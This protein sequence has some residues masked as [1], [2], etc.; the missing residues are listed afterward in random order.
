M[1]HNWVPRYVC[2]RKELPRTETNKILKREMQRQKFDPD[3][4]DDPIY[5]RERG[6]TEFKPLTRD[7]YERLKR[8]FEEAGNKHLLEI[9]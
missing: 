1:S 2:V 8:T 3:V 9:R 6:E 4:V 7:D 5:W